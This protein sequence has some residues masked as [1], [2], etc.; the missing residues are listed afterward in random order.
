MSHQRDSL[1]AKLTKKLNRELDEAA[2]STIGVEEYLKNVVI[3]ALDKA[4]RE[5]EGE[6]IKNKALGLEAARA[7]AFS[8]MVKAALDN[9]IKFHHTGLRN[10]DRPKHLSV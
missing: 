10:V 9:Y 6:T 5:I 4:Q 3:N 1:I 7:A 2:E 8:K